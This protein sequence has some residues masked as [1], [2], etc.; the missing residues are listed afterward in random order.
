MTKEQ[1]HIFELLMEMMQ[2]LDWKLNAK[3][4]FE[5]TSEANKQLANHKFFWSILLCIMEKIDFNKFGKYF[6]SEFSKQCLLNQNLLFSSPEEN[7]DKK[8]F[9]VFPDTHIRIYDNK[10]T[11]DKIFYLNN[12]EYIKSGTNIITLENFYYF[13]LIAL[14]EK[15]LAYFVIAADVM[16]L[17]SEDEY[18]EEEY[19]KELQEMFDQ[20]EEDENFNL[21]IKKT[22][23]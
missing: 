18:M 8:L 13:F 17:V 7:K 5:S 15:A 20:K 12:S 2:N 22:L 3:K 10:F 16:D 4:I 23:N 9:F 19:K 6:I 14:C 11:T 21:V 1:K